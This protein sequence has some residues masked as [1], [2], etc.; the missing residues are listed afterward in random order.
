MSEEQ[1]YPSLPEQAKNLAKFSFEVVRAALNNETSLLVSDEVKQQRLETC[2]ACEYYD[3][4]QVRCRHCGC[5]LEHKV[6]FAIDS[7][8]L[9][10][11]THSDSKWVDHEY[12]DVLDRIERGE[13]NPYEV[14]GPQFPL[15]PKLGELFTH[16]DQTW[17]WDG[18][19]WKFVDSE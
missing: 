18:R 14:E 6:Q 4:K 19:M 3:E 5:F 7:C 13:I 12:Q 1:S 17:Q 11:W 10:K 16:E 8:P 2:R 9:D 15:E